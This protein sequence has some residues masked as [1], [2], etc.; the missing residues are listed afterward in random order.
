MCTVHR[1]AGVNIKRD[2]EIERQLNLE[3]EKKKMLDII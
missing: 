2:L 1:T 3:I